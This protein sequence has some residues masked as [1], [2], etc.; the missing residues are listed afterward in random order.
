MCFAACAFLNVSRVLLQAEAF[1]RVQKK[2]TTT[3]DKDGYAV[4]DSMLQANL[5]RALG[6]QKK[7]IE[8][9]DL[10]EA[11]KNAGLANL[12]HPD[13]W[14]DSGAVR[15]LASQMKNKKFVACDL[16]K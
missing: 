14:P 16:H 15:E 2:D 13:Q 7:K 8:E 10:A 5:L 12:F 11:M 6:P 1:K 3:I 4:E 9:I